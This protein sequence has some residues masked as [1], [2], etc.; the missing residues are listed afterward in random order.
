[1]EQTFAS[2]DI[3]TNTLLLTI[4]RRDAE[5][6]KLT[7]LEDIHSIARL[8]Q[9]VD[10]ARIIHEDAIVRAET[11]LLRYQNLCRE[12]SVD[13]LRAVATSCLRDAANRIDVCLRLAAALGYPV[14][15][16]SGD[17]EARLCF[18]GSIEDDSPT[19][20]IDIGGGS[21]EVISGKD[22]AIEFRTSIDIGAVRLTERY[23]KELP[24]SHE[25]ITQAQAEIRKA[26]SIVPHAAL[27]PI[28]AVAGTPT[29]LAAMAL[30]LTE[31]NAD[32][33]HNYCLSYDDIAAR[34]SQLL[35]LTPSEIRQIPGVHPKRAD[36]LPAGALILRSILDYASAQC[37]MVSTKGL[38]YGVL[39]ERAASTVMIG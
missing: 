6:S 32:V 39:Y 25:C 18:L 16:I 22:G 35:S 23:F 2:I 5:R 15:V 7:V 27:Y 36:I 33:I 14:E 12:Y 3:G 13:S 11:I 8:G 10:A 9:G 20:I 30:H 4:A 17:E 29:T 28:R 26:V 19:T 24:A 38:R 21:T 37:C 31:Y 34:T 1:M